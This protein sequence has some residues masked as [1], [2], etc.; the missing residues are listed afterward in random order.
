MPNIP[1]S[2]AELRD[3][4]LLGPKLSAGIPLEEWPVRLPPPGARGAKDIWRGV[5]WEEALEAMAD[6]GFSVV[7]RV[8]AFR[9]RADRPEEFCLLWHPAGF[10]ALADSYSRLGE[11]E[12]GPLRRQANSVVI[13]FESDLGHGA[14]AARASSGFPGSGGPSYGADAALRERRHVDVANGGDSFLSVLRSVLAVSR[15]LPLERWKDTSP[16]IDP[17]HFSIHPAGSGPS[18]ASGASAAHLG[19]AWAESLPD[20]IRAIALRSVGDMEIVRSN[21]SS[22]A[23]SE[24]IKQA[25]RVEGLASRW[26]SPETSQSI[27]SWTEAIE[28]LADGADPSSLDY[29]SL[30][31]ESTPGGLHFLRAL[32][33][34]LR[35]PGV[36]EAFSLALGSLT[37]ERLEHLANLPDAA[38]CT[39]G[40]SFFES[41]RS[42]AFV[43]LSD[44]E[45]LDRGAEAFSALAARLGPRLALS[46]PSLSALGLLLSGSTGAAA[47]YSFQSYPAHLPETAPALVSI[48]WRHGLRWDEG[49]RAPFAFL[50][51]P[52]SNKDLRCS[53]PLDIPDPERSLDFLLGLPC[54]D[55]LRALL[56][57]RMLSLRASEA[58]ESP[59]P[60]RRAL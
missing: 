45:P 9:L 42:P 3:L 34:S 36:P 41:A 28:A 56:E 25:N 21:L 27:A 23:A 20:P 8:S 59:P 14:S 18:L 55:S 40:M 58:P 35:L 52:S 11:S 29:A 44:E 47:S 31:A 54:P 4:A 37:D 60:A 50:D 13:Y 10:L 30:L 46:S 49:I 57:A 32:S 19:K 2:V 22:F 17:G 26:A 39:L 53:E 38:G 5:G 15:P 1:S 33:A 12:A 16:H 51:A 43:S 24:W 6:A 48:A 7:R